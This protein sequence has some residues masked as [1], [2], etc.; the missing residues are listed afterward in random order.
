MPPGSI[1]GARRTSD[2]SHSDDPPNNLTIRSPLAEQPWAWVLSSAIVAAVFVAFYPVGKTYQETVF[3]LA[4]A[5][6]SMLIGVLLGFLFGVPHAV[7]SKGDQ[8]Q[9]DGSSSGNIRY[10]PST[11][12]EQISDWLTKILVGVGLTQLRQVPD[13][14]HRLGKFLAQGLGGSESDAAFGILI[15]LFFTICGFLVGFLWMRLYLQRELRRADDD[16]LA[17][18]EQI[19]SQPDKD[20]AALTGVLRQLA[21]SSD[22]D[23]PDQG[24]LMKAIRDASPVARVQ[25][26]EQ[27]RR[28]RKDGKCIE[29]TIP[30]FQA[31]IAADQAQQYHRIYGQLAYALREKKPPDLQGAIQ[32]LTQAIKIRDENHVSGY[33]LY[34]LNRA[35]SNM[36]LDKQQPSDSLKMSIAADIRKVRAE[37]QETFTQEPA[38][39]SWIDANTAWLQSHNVQV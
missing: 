34:E 17:T 38:F 19:K 30:V 23:P 7:E 22:V 14:L 20:A 3:A 28:T 5:A 35:L 9:T 21:C 39:Q 32:N 6:A 27:A 16:L 26:F 31:L 18:I 4:I 37:S 2:S 1:F 25:I 8:A 10:K 13:E 12:L 33:A 36:E 24:T 11:A 15:F 29:R